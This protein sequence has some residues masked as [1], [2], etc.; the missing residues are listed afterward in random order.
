MRLMTDAQP[1]SNSPLYVYHGRY[2]K[3]PRS[4]LFR[5][6]RVKSDAIAARNSGAGGALAAWSAAIRDSTAAV[7]AAAAG[8]AGSALSSSW[9]PLSSDSAAEDA[10]PLSVADAP[11]SS[12][13]VSLLP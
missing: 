12:V 11:L 2:E 10:G 5:G 4:P 9:L 13:W 8:L 3:P 6:S 7:V 1:Q